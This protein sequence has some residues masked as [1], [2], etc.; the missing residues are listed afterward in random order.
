MASPMRSL[1]AT[2]AFDSSGSGTSV[3][4]G[5]GLSRVDI[6][7]LHFG[8]WSKRLSPG[9][10]IVGFSEYPSRLLES[11]KI[12]H[13]SGSDDGCNMPAHAYTLLRM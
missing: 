13:T 11:G 7:A 1:I 8:E 3:S 6:C 4:I 10:S 5:L 2:K 9:T 12:S